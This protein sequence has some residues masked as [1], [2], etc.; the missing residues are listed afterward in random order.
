MFNFLRNMKRGLLRSWE[1]FQ[2]PNAP[3]LAGSHTVFIKIALMCTAF[4]QSQFLLKFKM[5][6]KGNGKN[7]YFP[8]FSCFGYSFAAL[9][10]RDRKEISDIVRAL[11]IGCNSPYFTIWVRGTRLVCKVSSCPARS[12]DCT[13]DIYPCKE[14]GKKWWRD[15][16]WMNPSSFPSPSSCWP[17]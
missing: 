14:L 12:K 11:Y 9:D 15:W 16:K 1:V 3:I 7:I 5:K 4:K 13:C 10:M 2:K 6:N 8:Q 17:P